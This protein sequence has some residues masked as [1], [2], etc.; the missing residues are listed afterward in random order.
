ML[1]TL[2]SVLR[3]RR[4]EFDS[5]KRRL[6]SAANTDDLRRLA[7]RRLP[8][9][10]FDYIDGGAE[11]EVAMRANRDAFG[12]YE[13]CPRVLRD[14]STVDTSSTLLGAPLPFPLVLAPTGYTRI[15]DPQGELAVARAAQRSGV[16]YTLS[17]MSTRSIE[18]VA[19]AGGTGRRWFQVYVWRDRALVR[20]MVERAAAAG[21]EA[22]V[23]TVDTA[24]LGR[25]ERDVRRGFTLPPKLGLETILDGITHPG[26]TWRFA[27]SEPILF[28]NVATSKVGGNQY[29]GSRPIALAEKV[30]SQFDPALSW[31]DIEWFRSMWNGPI[32]L[33]GVQSVA[34][35]RLAV[36]HG[37]D[38]IALSNH[39]GRQLD[40]A[41]AILELVAPVAQ[42]V[43]GSIEIICDGGVR[44]GSDM[45]KALA[46]G[47]NACMVGRAYLYG[48]GAAGE[49][50]V[51]RVLEWLLDELR[52][53][54]ALIGATTIADID[55]E[56]VRRRPT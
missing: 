13:F 9:G 14:V 54:M 42:E 5:T 18:E 16:P 20:D 45:V 3:F 40:S 8:A 30:S 48:L 37:I 19:E 1:D 35:A 49:A 15:A 44:R 55:S 31:A 47:A 43:G 22:L 56:H 25:R 36:E 10:V 27:R 51:D 28:A 38:A 2:R 23:I 32:V 4:F 41:P 24:S 12:R 26:W 6:A 52:R 39:G 34:D 17:T 11:D 21:Y 50:G 53:T 46:L 29:D 33:K 7:K